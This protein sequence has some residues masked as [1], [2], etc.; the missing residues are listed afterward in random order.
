MTAT[1]SAVRLKRLSWLFVGTILWT[2]IDQLPKQEY[3]EWVF[4]LFHASIAVAFSFC[5]LLSY[6]WSADAGAKRGHFFVIFVVSFWMMVGFATKAL[7][8]TATLDQLVLSMEGA[9]RT[10]TL[11]VIACTSYLSES[12]PDKQAAWNSLFFGSSGANLE[13]AK[14]GTD[15]A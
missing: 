1:L 2:T 13:A 15:R 12:K 5:L 3:P 14:N 9:D 6:W 7:I 10:C 8:V 4:W 11:P